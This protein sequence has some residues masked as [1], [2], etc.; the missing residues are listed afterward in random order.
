M[1]AAAEA[2]SKPFPFVRMDFYSVGGRAV[3]GEMT[4][5]PHGCVDLGYTD[6]AQ[7]ELG[8]RIELPEPIVE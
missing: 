6:V 7:R 1:L 5:T 8:R 2:L 3:I 4:F